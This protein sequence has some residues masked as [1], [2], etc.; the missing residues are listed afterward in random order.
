MYVIVKNF[1]RIFLLQIWKVLG[2]CML[3]IKDRDPP[4]LRGAQVSPGR[5]P[6]C[7]LP[8]PT[9]EAVGQLQSAHFSLKVRFLCL[10]TPRSHT[11]LPPHKETLV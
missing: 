10:C 8:R 2:V 5:H 7:S 9:S 3:D 1:K 6:H 4:Y 11:A